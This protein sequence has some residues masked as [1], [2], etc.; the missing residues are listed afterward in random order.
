[1]HQFCIYLSM[2]ET[3]TNT[4]QIQFGVLLSELEL[5]LISYIEANKEIPQVNGQFLETMKQ[6]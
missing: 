4:Q 6:N 1:M 5:S 2:K 3:N